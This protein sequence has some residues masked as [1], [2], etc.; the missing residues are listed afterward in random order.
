MPREYTVLSFSRF[1]KS[2]LKFE[3]SV[4]ADNLEFNQ[5]KDIDVIL[6]PIEHPQR[7]LKIVEQ[8]KRARSSQQQFS[9]EIN[10]LFDA[11]MQKA[12]TG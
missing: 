5:I 4:T 2:F 9:Q 1:S 8:I 6:P 7:F 3:R 10:T 11:L 12:F